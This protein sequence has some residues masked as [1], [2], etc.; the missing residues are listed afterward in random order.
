MRFVG[1]MKKV[2]VAVV[3]AVAVLLASDFVNDAYNQYAVV[4]YS[5]SAATTTS[6]PSNIIQISLNVY[7]SG[8]ANAV[9][10]FTV[11]VVNATIQQVSIPNLTENELANFCSYNNETATITNLTVTA[12]QT[13]I[14]WA[15][16]SVIPNIGVS[17]FSVSSSASL[18]LDITHPKDT[19]MA[20]I[21][22][23][24]F[25][26]LTSQGVYAQSFS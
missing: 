20:N 1:T 19:T 3:I 11:N 15:T 22:F 23:E 5:L 14:E 26:I 18:P 7:N 6:A 12:G 10:T 17:S 16:V 24:L 2:V 4:G 25:Y 21:P 9:P 8:N 13:S